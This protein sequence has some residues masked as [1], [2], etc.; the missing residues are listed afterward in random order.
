MFVYKYSIFYDF[1][2]FHIIQFLNHKR[3]G[4][5]KLKLIFELIIDW[6]KY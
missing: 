6:E 1:L 3:K 4:T 5:Q 2:L